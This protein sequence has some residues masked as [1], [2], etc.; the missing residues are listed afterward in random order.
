ML[1]LATR[2]FAAPKLVAGGL[3]ALAIVVLVVMAV[4]NDD[5]ANRLELE[6]DAERA[7]TAIDKG[8][9]NALE[10]VS[11]LDPDDIDQ[12]LRGRADGPR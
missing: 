4:R 3:G 1:G 9:S 11:D 10:D 2:F 5:K 7:A 8:V 12:W 6:L